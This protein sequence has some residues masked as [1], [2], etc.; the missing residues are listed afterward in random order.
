VAN[1]LIYT[2]EQFAHDQQTYHRNPTPTSQLRVVVGNG[3]DKQRLEEIARDAGVS[4]KVVF[5]GRVSDDLLASYYQTCDVF[6]LPSLKEGF[7]I[8]FIEAM[9]Y[10]NSCVGAKT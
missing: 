5:A 1:T 8:V 3:A 6:V 4:G 2:D 9:Y 7:G 10:S